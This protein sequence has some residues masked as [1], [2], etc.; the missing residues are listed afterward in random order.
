MLNC[1]WRLPLICGLCLMFFAAPLRA[2]TIEIP[3]TGDGTAV[4]SAL[5][6]AYTLKHPEVRFEIPKSIGSSGG[7][8]AAGSGQAMLARVARTIK[9]KEEH[10]NL[11]YLPYARVPAVF[12]VTDDIP[13]E[14]LSSQQICDIY[15]GDITN[16]K[17][18]GGPDS[19]IRV[20]RR[21]DGD[22]TLSQLRESFPGFA[23][24]TITESAEIATKT[25]EMF[26]LMQNQKS[27]IGFGPYDV[28]KNS[29]M[30]IIKVDG[31]DPMFSGYPSLT[32]LAFVYQEERLNE[33]VRRFL[34]FA[35]S[36]EANLPILAAGG[37]PTN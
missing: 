10:Y 36:A 16:W 2:E 18:L 3:G 6:A 24:L 11:K 26:A 30:R 7:I 4:L 9:Q 13:I 8:K 34:E 17:Q 15:R 31:R 29:V 35:L 27:A 25:P 20:I 32:T 21:E 33:N 23:N 22:S 5:T 19:K 28:A 12:F 37:I 1:T 14:Y